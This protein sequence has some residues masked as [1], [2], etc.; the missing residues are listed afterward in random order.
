MVNSIGRLHRRFIKPKQSERIADI[1]VELLPEQGRVLDVGCGTGKI[2]R[3]IQE[4][5]PKLTLEG[6]DVLVQAEAEVCVK[7]FDGANIP[8]GDNVFDAVIFVDVL[9]HTDNHAQ[10]LR[11]A[12]RVSKGA[13]IVKDH[14]CKG[15]LA[16]WILVFMDW[17]GN[18]SLG[19]HSIHSY[20]SKEQWTE[21]FKEIDIA[22]PEMM[23]VKELYPFPFSLV[24]ERNKQ[25][26][27]RLPP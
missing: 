18:R 5:N 15:C 2:S 24:F 19:I 7:L 8:Y 20:L 21:L 13:V 23:M 10:L 27:F 22:E 14:I 12:L 4:R 6:I 26:I 11:E 17:V 16:F 25:V 3:L 1:L 9:H